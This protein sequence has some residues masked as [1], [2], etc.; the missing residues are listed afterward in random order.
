MEKML[1]FKKYFECIWKYRA[2]LNCLEF[3]FHHL[4]SLTKPQIR[5]VLTGRIKVHSLSVNRVKI[6]YKT[7]TKAEIQTYT[8]GKKSAN[9]LKPTAF[10]YCTVNGLKITESYLLFIAGNVPPEETHP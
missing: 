6:Q 10:Y 4:F 9:K 3:S 1:E 7:N 5:R 2:A 8:M